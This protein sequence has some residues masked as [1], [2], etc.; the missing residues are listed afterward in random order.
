MHASLSQITAAVITGTV[1]NI[2]PGNWNGIF[3][4]LSHTDTGHPDLKVSFYSTANGGKGSEVIFTF[5]IIST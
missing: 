5:V 2:L 1:D 4:V 3:P